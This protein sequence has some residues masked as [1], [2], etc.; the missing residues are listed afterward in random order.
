[1]GSARF[2]LRLFALA[3]IALWASNAS[4]VTDRN[5]TE[6]GQMPPFAD[7]VCPVIHSNALQQEKYAQGGG[8]AERTVQTFAEGI[9]K[10]LP[11]VPGASLALGPSVLPNGNLVAGTGRGIGF[12]SLTVHDPVTGNIVWMTPRARP[13]I[14]AL[15]AST[16]A[17]QFVAR[18]TY[19]DGQGNV[20]QSPYSAAPSAI[21][22]AVLAGSLDGFLRAFSSVDGS[23]LWEFDST[24]SFTSPDGRTGSGGSVGVSGPIVAGDMVF[25]GTGSLLEGSTGNVLFAFGL[26]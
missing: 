15:D 21:P 18:S 3:L 5:L 6:R 2:S 10:T 13:G 9:V 17:E 12:S 25:A 24:Q 4:A 19:I 16:G 14:Y 23:L 22:G 7:T 26:P 20:Q 8:P 1:M 11:L